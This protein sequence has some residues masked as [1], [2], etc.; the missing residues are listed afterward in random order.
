MLSFRN[1]TH[2]FVSSSVPR[3]KPNGKKLKIFVLGHSTVPN[4]IFEPNVVPLEFSNLS[5]FNFLNQDQPSSKKQITCDH[6]NIEAGVEVI[7]SQC[8]GAQWEKE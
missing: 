8:P 1:I 3:G 7:T 4:L 6:K 2:S 5:S